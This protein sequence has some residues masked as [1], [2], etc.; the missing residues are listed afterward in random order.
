V[1][2]Q[3]DKD[4]VNDTIAEKTINRGYKPSQ[5]GIYEN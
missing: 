4:D 1:D 2:P 5:A 3:I